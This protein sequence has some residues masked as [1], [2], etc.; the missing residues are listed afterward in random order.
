MNS[1]R[2]KIFGLPNSTRILLGSSFL[3]LIVVLAYLPAMRGGFIWDDEIMLTSNPA[4]KASDG[5][6]TIWFTTKWIDYFPLTS[7]SFWLEWRLWQMH[8]AGYHVTNVL[9]HAAGAVLLWRVLR[10]LQVPGAWAAALIFGVHP[11][12]VASVAWIAERKNTLSIVFY[13]VSILWYLRF[14]SDSRAPQAAGRT[15]KWYWLSLFAFLLALLA[16]TSVVGLP[17][18]LLLCIWWQ[19]RRITRSDL[20]RTFPFFALALALGVVTVWMQ[21]KVTGSNDSLLVRLLGGG[22]AVWF[23]LAK[24]VLPTKLT[25][26][27]PSWEINPGSIA[28]YAP[29]LLALGALFLFWRYRARWGRAWFFGFGSFIVAL[30]PV[31]GIF[32]MLWFDFSRVA[33]HLQYLALPGIIALVVG[34]TCHWLRKAATWP[35]L[36]PVRLLLPA[37]AAA[38]VAA[39]LSIVTWRHEQVF[40]NNEVLW[41]DNEAKYPKCGTPHAVL[42]L[43]LSRDGRLEEAMREY[44]AALRLEVDTSSIHAYMADTFFKL[45]RFEEAIKEYQAAL[46][47]CLDVFHIQYSLGLALLKTG[48]FEEAIPRFKAA[49]ALE[50]SSAEATSNLGIALSAKGDTNAAFAYLSNAL[51][52][53]PNLSGA[54]CQ[55]GYFLQAQGKLEDARQHF[56]AATLSDPAFADPHNGLGITLIQQGKL[57]EGLAELGEAIRIN[58]NYL[59]AHLNLGSA[60]LQVRAFDAAFAEYATAARLAP[61]SPEAHY[62]LGH[63]LFA[64]RKFA[65]AALEYRIAVRLRPGFAD[66]HY[67]LGVAMSIL[68]K[69]EEAALQMTE[70]LKITPSHAYA[71]NQLGVALLKQGRTAEAI[72]N[73]REAVRLNPQ[74]ILALNNLA[75]LLATDNHGSLRDGAEAVRVASHAVALTAEKDPNPLE[76][77]AAAYAESGRFAEAVGA[78]QHAVD[79]AQSSNQTNLAAKIRLRLAHYQSGKPF[80][81]S[82]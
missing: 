58:P 28:A 82:P 9:L 77:L 10:R 30:G 8:P 80:H 61:D 31:L 56:V 35:L 29:G 65:E 53:N 27:Y 64:Q 20:A 73:F 44:Q 32:N 14:D 71:R 33:D 2:D 45:G 70:V 46:P 12:C 78:A 4:I 34:G 55:L 41:R 49:V 75:W 21:G 11:V 81:D 1:V 15:R 43:L 52:M 67:E 22:W 74:F 17:V 6:Y 54:Q 13:L 40:A 7:S 62:H 18:V 72:G 66:A 37:S 5:L 39:V 47:N 26:V 23:Y 42:G 48:R 50:P 19:R 51:Q 25:V 3:F 38:V 24:T 36:A 57:K 69:P 60:F 16:K 59:E 79:L 68:G 63:T 76:I